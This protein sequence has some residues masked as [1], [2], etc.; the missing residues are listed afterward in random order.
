MRIVPLVVL[1][2]LVLALATFAQPDPPASPPG[3]KYALMIGIDDYQV[4]K[5]LAG[6]ANDVALLESVLVG[7][8]GFDHI[9]TL[10]NSA[11]TRAEIL[12][13]FSVLA[14]KAERDDTVVVHYSGHGS[15]MRD[16]AFGDELDGWDET[17]VAYDSRTQN[18]FDITDD[19]LNAALARITRKTSNVA[20]IFDSCHSGSI[21]RG[22]ATVRKVDDDL[23]TPPPSGRPRAAESLNDFQ[24]ADASYVLMMGSRAN[25]LSNETEFDGVRHGALTYYLTKQLLK[26]G[27]TTT[28]RDVMEI[29]SAQV[30]SMFGS[31]H[32]DLEGLGSDGVVFGQG[33]ATARPYLLVD[34]L[35]ATTVRVHGGAVYGLTAGSTA[36]LYPPGTKTFD[37]ATRVA[38]ARISRVDAF[39]AEATIPNGLQVRP[40]SRAVVEKRKYPDAK[41]RVFFDPGVPATFAAAVKQELSLLGT[42]VIAPGAGAADLVLVAR[43]DEVLLTGADESDRSPAVKLSDA[44][45][46][47]HVVNQIVDWAEWSFVLGLDNPDGELPVT[48][49]IMP[50]TGSAGKEFSAGDRVKV[51]ITNNADRD[52]YFT[53]VDLSTDGTRSVLYPRAGQQNAV[54]PGKTVTRNFQLTVPA[55]R[56]SVVDTFKLFA[57]EVPIKAEAFEHGAIRNVDD[58]EPSTNPLARF[59]ESSALGSRAA[60]EAPAEGWDALEQT[61]RIKREGTRADS[62]VMHFPANAVDPEGNTRGSLRGCGEDEPFD[63]ANPC[64]EVRP[65]P[66][67]REM[68]EVALPAGNTRSLRTAGAL[69]DKA[70]ELRA[71]TGAARV[72]PALDA[73][74]GDWPVEDPT[75][76]R[77]GFQRAD[78]DGAKADPLWS[79]R[80]INA[81]AAWDLLHAKGAGRRDGNEGRGVIVGHPDTGYREHPE[82][83]NADPAMTPT[84]YGDGY[85]FYDRDPDSLDP[86]ESSGLLT[87]PGHGTKSGSVIVS[88]KGKQWPSSNANELVTGVAPGAH[89]VPLRVHKSVV[90]FDSTRLAKAILEAAGDDRSRVRKKADVIS[91]S[92]GGLPSWALWKAVRYAEKR[93]VIVVAAAGNEVGFVVWPARFKETIAVAASNVDC[94][95]WEGSSKGPGVDITAPGESVWMAHTDKNG[96]YS[97]RM[98]QGTTFA[99]ATTAGIAA[100]WLDY[101]NGEQALQNLRAS[102]GLTSAF[103][104][105]LQST[106]WRPESPP[107][108]KPQGVSC[109]PQPAWNASA[110]GPGMADAAAT[111]SKP[112]TTAAA[113]RALEPESVSDLPLFRSLF[114]EDVPF[115]TVRARYASIFGAATSAEK[116]AAEIFEGELMY[117]YA[118]NEDVRGLIENVTRPE[119]PVSSAAY[120]AIRRTLLGLDLSSRMRTLLEAHP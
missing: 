85:D 97:V 35:N 59:L 84:L 99:T 45:A 13:Q 79:L 80:Y 92:M 117:H 98:G 27:P 44:D 100:L 73:D 49:S 74:L 1:T 56:S 95:I 37:S 82:I 58:L 106:A 54:S 14:D 10:L 9:T 77:G 3:K 5:D 103:R 39:D 17:M 7:K 53:L 8:F 66:G 109:K 34:P 30:T 23:R 115:E 78:K 102:G 70:Y 52:L 114:A 68:V 96:S 11:A 6:C 22:G 28:Y 116:A 62:F 33:S 41:L 89:I 25:E 120:P 26:A 107:S 61:L 19:E 4:V 48:M 67:D 118:T 110:L 50:S 18:V 108:K 69:W 46:V 36:G 75:S 87:N 64:Y 29:A 57:T 105:A 20:L 38:E 60:H 112:L 32:P 72:E 104:S 65:F 40:G 113:P 42:T 71:S 88:P 83:W 12:R 16:D 2:H 76:S 93:G 55:D 24:G 81:P 21:T 94:G 43:G 47:S 111:L 63:P 119:T 90:H 15:R 31:Q 101:H 51:A 91:I 86:L